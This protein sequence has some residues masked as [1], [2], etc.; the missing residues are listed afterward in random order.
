VAGESLSLV[1]VDVQERRQ[2]EPV[3]AEE[4]I[5]GR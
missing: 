5:K 1:V 2:I 4:L 3:I